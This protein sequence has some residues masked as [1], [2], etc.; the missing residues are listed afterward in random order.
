MLLEGRLQLGPQVYFE[1]GVWL[2]SDTGR[3]TIGGGSLLNLD[4]MVAAVD[5]VEIG[6]HCLLANGCR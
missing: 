6:E 1:S 5:R 4:V 2:T 3:I